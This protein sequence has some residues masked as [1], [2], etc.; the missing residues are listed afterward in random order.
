LFNS[1]TKRPARQSGG[2]FAVTPILDGGLGR[3]YDENI[4]APVAEITTAEQLFQEPGWGRCELP[5]GF[6]IEVRKVLPA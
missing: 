2:D 5:S 4:M 1:I 6:Q 3:A